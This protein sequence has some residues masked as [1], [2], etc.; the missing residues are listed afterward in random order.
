MTTEQKRAYVAQQ[1][2]VD[3]TLA[4]RCELLSLSRSSYYYQHTSSSP[5]TE[6]L[7]QLLD[8]HYTTFPFEGK[9]KRAKWLSEQV[10]Y[11]MEVYPYCDL[12]YYRGN[13]NSR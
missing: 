8:E 10:G 1:D 6:R 11:T 13:L 7:M 3:I 12:L 4:R 2:N 9:I 5:E